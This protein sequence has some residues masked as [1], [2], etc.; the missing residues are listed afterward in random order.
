[1]ARLLESYMIVLCVSFLGLLVCYQCS[2][3][4]MNDIKNIAGYAR[5]VFLHVRKNATLKIVV[6][7]KCSC[8]YY[9]E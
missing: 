1:M 2:S 5:I 7:L 4:T 8:Y 3:I 9:Y 6:L